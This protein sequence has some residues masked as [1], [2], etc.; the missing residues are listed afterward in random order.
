MKEIYATIIT[1]TTK[2]LVIQLMV[3]VPVTVVGLVNGVIFMTNVKS[4]IVVDMAS[5]IPIKVDVTDKPSTLLS[6]V[7]SI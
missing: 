3:L 2:V 6:G 4:L 1:V 5:V 7:M